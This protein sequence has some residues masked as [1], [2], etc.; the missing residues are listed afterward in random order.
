MQRLSARKGY[1]YFTTIGYDYSSRNATTIAGLYWLSG[2]SPKRNA[3]GAANGFA[4]PSP[5]PA[6]GLPRRV[7]SARLPALTADPVQDLQ[8][9]GV[10]SAE[11]PPGWHGLPSYIP[12]YNRRSVLTCAASRR[13][14][15]IWYVLEAVR[16]RVRAPAWRRWYYSHLC[17][18]GIVGG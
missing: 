16:S 18:S 5:A 1:D 12:Y 10:G 17:R 8:P 4:P 6:A 13:C 2:E 3:A 15:G 7:E 14:G 11:T 9:L